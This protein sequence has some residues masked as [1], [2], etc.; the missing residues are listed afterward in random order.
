MPK[1]SCVSAYTLAEV[2]I[3][4]KEPILCKG[5]EI[6]EEVKYERSYHSGSRD[7]RSI[8][9]QTRE[10]EFELKEPFDQKDLNTLLNAGL[11][12]DC[13]SIICLGYNAKGAPEALEVLEGCV[14]T[15]RTRSI[16]DHKAPELK[17]KGVALRT[18]FVKATH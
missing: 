7:P 11:N 3:P 10:V 8:N 1:E 14:V 12:G 16:G 13:F 9:L 4:G 6:T 2:K 18:R 17:I 5:I 15:S